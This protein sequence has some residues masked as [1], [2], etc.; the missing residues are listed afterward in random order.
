LQF[1]SEETGVAQ[2]FKRDKLFLYLQQNKI[3]IILIL[4]SWW[5][6][7]IGQNK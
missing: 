2:I 6:C 7:N 5:C 4:L 1:T 3:T